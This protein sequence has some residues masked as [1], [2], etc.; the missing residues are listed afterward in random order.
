MN[1]WIQ[2]IEHAINRTIGAPYAFRH[3][4]HVVNAEGLLQGLPSEWANEGKDGNRATPVTLNPIGK[5]VDPFTILSL[6][7]VLFRVFKYLSLADILR[8]VAAVS[9]RW[10]SVAYHNDLVFTCLF[11]KM[12]L[13]SGIVLLKIEESM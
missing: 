4:M 7:L 3:T 5:Q 6:E 2:A 13:C 1:E 8:R 12:T 11:R 9:T 10:K